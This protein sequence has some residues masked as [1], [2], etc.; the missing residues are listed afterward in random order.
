V[1]SAY[2][3]Y[4]FTAPVQGSLV[5]QRLQNLCIRDYARSKGMT[6]AFTVAEY[7]EPSQALVLFAQFGHG[8]AIAG[9]IFYS[10]LLL[11]TDASLRRR[12]YSKV[13]EQRLEVQFALENL[14]LDNWMETERLYRIRTDARLDATREELLRMRET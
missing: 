7:F 2:L 14:V 6:L 12:F 8:D 13:E 5:P 4:N 9:F 11:P 10:F 3:G 1:G